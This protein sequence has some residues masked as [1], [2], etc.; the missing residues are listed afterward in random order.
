MKI[1]PG[2]H[3]LTTDLFLP[4]QREMQTIDSIQNKTID[5]LQNKTIDSLQN[6]TIDS[7][8]NNLILNFYLIRQSLIEILYLSRTRSSWKMWGE[9]TE[10]AR[11]L[12]LVEKR[13]S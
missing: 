11:H 2:H 8:L 1:L 5:F 9:K 10:N 13:R 4:E 7:L 6:K 3:N 12:S